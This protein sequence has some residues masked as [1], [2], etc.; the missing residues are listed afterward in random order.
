MAKPKN[1]ELLHLRDDLVGIDVVVVEVVRD[2]K[3]LAFH[4][5]ADHAH[6]LALL[7]G[8]VDGHEREFSRRSQASSPD[9]VA[10]MS[11]RSFAR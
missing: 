8:H 3:D 1:P 9:T 10:V 6:D 7:G 2:G 5:V 11:E 4:E